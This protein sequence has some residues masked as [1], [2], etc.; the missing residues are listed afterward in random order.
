MRI[1][2]LWRYPVKSFSGE[3][4]TETAVDHRGIPFDRAFRFAVQ[5]DGKRKA[6]TGRQ[7]PQMLAYQAFAASGS[8][9]V[10]TPDGMLL[11]PGAELRAMLSSAYG[12]ALFLEEAQ[13]TDYPFFDDADLLI[14]NA[15]SVRTLAEE[16]RTPIDVLR[17]RPSIVVDGADAQPFAE[18]GWIGKSFTAGTARLQIVQRNVRCVMTN[19]DPQTCAVDPSFLTFLTEHHEQCFGVY[20][21]VAAP[22][23]IAVGDEWAPL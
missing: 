17:F 13:T 6:L 14:I 16:M 1:T 22:G 23:R 11:S 21:R 4:L 10:R 8:V 2:H 12:R 3:P 15:A 9:A 18:D 19:I 7:L 20:A 5:S